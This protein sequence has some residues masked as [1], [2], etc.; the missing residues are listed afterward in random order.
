LA[1][2][3][4][5]RILGSFG[6]TAST[7]IGGDIR[8]KILRLRKFLFFLGGILMAIWALLGV[9]HKKKQLLAFS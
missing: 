3:G 9:G 2:A 5:I 1:A 8:N 4:G 7:V 6:Y